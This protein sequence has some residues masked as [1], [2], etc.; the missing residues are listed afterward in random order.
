MAL[1]LDHTCIHHQMST[2][3]HDLKPH[4]LHTYLYF[5]LYCTVLL[6]IF[7]LLV[8]IQQLLYLS[9]LFIFH[10]LCIDLAL[11]PYQPSDSVESSY[12]VIIFLPFFQLAQRIR[13]ATISIDYKL[14]IIG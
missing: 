10:I 12:L 14:Y 6:Y 4:P 9:S 7:L 8:S 1:D 11:D 2:P 13:L 3:R 5:L